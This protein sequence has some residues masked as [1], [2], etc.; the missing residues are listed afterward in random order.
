MN[1]R[2]TP[3]AAFL[4]YG[5]LLP[6]IGINVPAATVLAL[7][8]L[9]LLFDFMLSLY[10]IPISHLSARISSRSLKVGNQL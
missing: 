3:V 5:L 4:L 7:I 10:T 1:S 8:P 2:L 6:M 9:I